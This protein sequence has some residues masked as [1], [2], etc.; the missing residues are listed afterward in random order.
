MGCG[1]C[2]GDGV[3]TCDI[4]WLGRGKGLGVLGEWVLDGFLRGC[5]GVI[6]CFDILLCSV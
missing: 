3:E 6:Y 5:R 4:W 1:S 2:D